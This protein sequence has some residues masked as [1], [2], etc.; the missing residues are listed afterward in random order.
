MNLVIEPYQKSDGRIQ[1]SFG[2]DILKD[3]SIN[4]QAEV[5]YEHLCDFQILFILACILLLLEFVHV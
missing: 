2:E 4:Q 5:N 3:S 1:T